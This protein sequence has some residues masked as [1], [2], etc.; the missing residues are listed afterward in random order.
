MLEFIYFR[1]FSRF[2]RKHFA[3]INRKRYFQFG[4]KKVHFYILEILFHVIE[5]LGQNPDNWMYVH[6]ALPS[7]SAAMDKECP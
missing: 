3:F 7:C 2:Y 5:Y 6:L 4:K 1:I